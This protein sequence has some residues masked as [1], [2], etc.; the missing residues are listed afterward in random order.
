MHLQWRPFIGHCRNSTQLQGQGEVLG[1][2]Y[3]ILGTSGRWIETRI[4]AGVTT[5]LRV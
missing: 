5:T 3:V 1:L 2:A 4:G